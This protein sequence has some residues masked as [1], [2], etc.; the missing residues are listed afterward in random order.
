MKTERLYTI[1]FAVGVA[2]PLALGSLAW[3][4]GT[5]DL[6]PVRVCL[7]LAA[8]A[9]WPFWLF[10]WLPAMSY[11]KATWLF[12]L[13]GAGCLVA[14]GGLYMLMA[15]LQRWTRHFQVRWQF[16]ALC[17]CYPVVLC[18]GFLVPLGVEWAA[19]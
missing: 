1:W 2:A 3:L 8:M 9:S 4:A 5:I 14:N 13:V 10:L 18:L 17:A 6:D 15:L 7:G 11:P 12:Y 19:Q 16:A